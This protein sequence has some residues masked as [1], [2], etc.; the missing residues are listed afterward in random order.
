MVIFMLTFFHRSKGRAH[1]LCKRGYF[2][3]AIDT[4]CAN[5]LQKI[6]S[7][8]LKFEI[9]PSLCPLRFLAKNWYTKFQGHCKNISTFTK[10]VWLPLP[11]LHH[12]K[13]RHSEFC[14]LNIVFR[15]LSSLRSL[16]MLRLFAS[17]EQILI[18]SMSA[19]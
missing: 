6:S 16:G 5:F 4:K 9:V 1:P 18:I 11:R 3:N 2:C 14:I 19:C 12:Y 7:G 8:I 17:I 10:W 15:F 13:V